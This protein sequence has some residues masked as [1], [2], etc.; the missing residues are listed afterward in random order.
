MYEQFSTFADGLTVAFLDRTI[1]AGAATTSGYMRGALMLMTAVAAVLLWTRRLDLWW[2]VRRFGIAI[3]VIGLLQVGTYNTYIREPFWTTIPNAIAGGFTGGSVSVTTA[4]RFDIMSDAAS[5]VVAA[6]DAQATGLWNFR[7]A[8]A[9][10]MADGAMK[11]FIGICFALSLVARQATALLISAGPFLLVAAIF[12]VSRPWVIGWF[13]RLI[14]LAAWT[15]FVTALS[16]MT[17]AGSLLF[18]QRTAAFAGG[19][20]ER[21]D[22]LWKLTIWMLINCAVMLGLPYYA[23]FGSGGGGGVQAGAGAA[24]GLAAAGMGRAAGALRNAAGALRRAG[25][26]S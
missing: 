9:I 15:L 21:V 8:F 2:V 11:I 20:S 1:A 17:L 26:R 10:A 13:G 4:R 16:E 5:H 24:V 23:A 18:I 14:A 22:G 12:D 3:V 19:L 6:A 25:N 7:P